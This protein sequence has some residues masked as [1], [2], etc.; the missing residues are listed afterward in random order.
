MLVDSKRVL[1]KLLL[2][3][4]VLLFDVFRSCRSDNEKATELMMRAR[5]IDGYFWSVF[6]F[7]GAQNK[8]AVRLTLEQI[9][10]IQRMCKTYDEFEMTT[11]SQGIENTPDNKIACLMGIHGGHSIDSSLATLRMYYELGVRYMGL[12]NECN[13]PWAQSSVESEDHLYSAVSGLGSFGSKVVKEM[14]RL[15]MM[16]DLSHASQATAMKVLGISKA[17]V[18]F[19]HSLALT[20]C[21]HSRNIPDD[22][23]QRLKQNNGIVMVTFHATP[24]SCGGRTVDIATI[25]ENLDYIRNVA[26]SENIG[27]S[28]SFDGV[29]QPS[30]GLEDIS[31]YPTLIQKLLD[32]G[33]N[34]EEVRG[35]LRENFL[36]VFRE[37]E[38]REVPAKVAA[39][40][41][42]SGS[43]PPTPRCRIIKPAACPE[44]RLQPQRNAAAAVAVSSSGWTAP[45]SSQSKQLPQ[46]RLNW[47]R[48]L[49]AQAGRF[50][51]WAWITSSPD[52]QAL[53]SDCKEF[54]SGRLRFSLKSK[55]EE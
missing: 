3:L 18:I 53:P 36:R 43:A 10:V 42:C 6:A 22:I 21:Q 35:I 1:P 48:L 38:R 27:L 17:P 40:V 34:E 14:N 25:I 4:L 50:P 55:V 32:K 26:G 12:T 19:T 20:V 41:S 24:E 7:C 16:I 44:R 47:H 23:L 52:S 37:V 31:K 45:P 49:R 11:S 9:D 13:T 29:L 15:G 54:P 33:W 30:E 28:G 8:D 46:A 39:L 5:M 51:I 2:W